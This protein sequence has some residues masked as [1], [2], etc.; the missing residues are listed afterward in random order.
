MPTLDEIIEKS[1]IN[2]S[3]LSAKLKDLD[4]LHQNIIDLKNAAILGKESSE[5]IPLEFEKK[6]NELKEISVKYL[7]DIG[8]ATK[9]YLDFNNTLFIKNLKVL[10][11]NTKDFKIELMNLKNLLQE[12]KIQI[13]LNTLEV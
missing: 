7:K 4:K 2:V 11:D 13:L 5:K 3:S 9:T 1:E 12:L 10:S 6:F 8:I